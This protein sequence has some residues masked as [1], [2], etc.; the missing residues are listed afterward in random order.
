MKTSTYV[1]ACVLISCIIILWSA[2]VSRAQ[3]K[4]PV[5]SVYL[6]TLAA[7]S[8]NIYSLKDE[9]W[10]G[11]QIGPFCIFR[12][13]GPV[14]IMN[15]PQPP[16]EARYLKDSIYVFNQ[17]DYALAG[18]T[19]TP[20]NN[21]LTAHNNYGQPMYVSEHQFYSELFHE[22]HHVY[23]RTY[24]KQ[25]K[26]DNPAELLTYPE[27]YRND[28]LKQYENEAL[29]EMLL[30]PDNRFD[31]N[32]NRFY[33]CRMLRQDII[34]EKYINYEKSVES[35]EGPATYCEHAYMKKFGTSVQ[36][37]EFIHK[38]FYYS[39]TDPA[40]G[41]EG[42][43]NKHLL[44]GMA[45]CIILSRHYKNW[46]PE[47]YQSG[48]QLNDFFF[49]RFHP[50][51]IRLPAL[52]SYEAKAMYF[53]KLEKEKHS[54]HLDAFNSQA[55]RKITLLFNTKP[56]FRG[57]D[58]MHAEAVNDSLILHTTLLKLGKGT[59]AFTAINQGTL[60]LINKQVWHVKQVTFFVPASAIK[61]DGNTF[62]CSDKN[63]SVNWKFIKQVKQENEYILTLE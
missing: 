13:N 63:M 45:Q 61:F 44:T 57:F 41:R 19:Q 26:F 34:G 46:Q 40:Y 23:Q 4:E 7:F 58:P 10:P 24:I 37:Q 43:R 50:Q 11:M 55:G 51:Q 6:N 17:A 32:L 27:D 42:L 20:I 60:T 1:G 59:N 47:Y 49:S 52:T 38:R 30:G 22:L 48:L 5:D 8:K 25:L 53:T 39:L 36:E 14:F 21:H 9:V 35:A 15:H 2:P 33:T 56:E 12:V 28:A 62:T 31:D 16:R 3:I 18:T 29:L 54:K